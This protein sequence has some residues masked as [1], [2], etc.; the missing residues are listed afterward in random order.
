MISEEKTF[1]ENPFDALKILIP[2][3]IG[4]VVFVAIIVSFVG[5][6]R[7]KNSMGLSAGGFIFMI[8]AINVGLF[9]LIALA[10]SLMKR[11]TIV[12]N[13][14]GCAI[15]GID[16]WGNAG[17][18]ESFRW[19]DV[20]DTNLNL[21]HVGKGGKQLNLEVSIGGKN[22]RL[23]SCALYNRQEFDELMEAVNQSTPHLPYELKGKKSAGNQRI[24]EET[25]NYCKVARL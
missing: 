22:L 21:V 4:I 24:V 10:L 23:L 11:R 12:C 1:V 9:L 20:T 6:P 13:V 5:A 19:R 2:V 14:E 25:A 7:G 17:A 16:A 18:T 8:F 15:N 3:Q